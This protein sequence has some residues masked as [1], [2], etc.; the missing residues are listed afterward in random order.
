MVEKWQDVFRQNSGD[1]VTDGSWQILTQKMQISGSSKWIY[2]DII[3]IYE[4]L[5]WKIQDVKY[6]V[7]E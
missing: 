7:M 4:N 2:R 1:T 3:Q 5:N 6:V